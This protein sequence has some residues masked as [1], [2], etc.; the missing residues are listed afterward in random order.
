VFAGVIVSMGTQCS[1]RHHQ[2]LGPYFV[3]TGNRNRP[4]GLILDD[5]EEGNALLILFAYNFECIL[6]YVTPITD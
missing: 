6:R 2:P 4:L 1:T 3:P 5:E